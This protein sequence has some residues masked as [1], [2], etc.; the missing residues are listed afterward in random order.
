MEIEL[1]F[2][3]KVFVKTS[4]PYKAEELAKQRAE[5]IITHLGIL[6][7]DFEYKSMSMGPEID[8]KLEQLKDMINGK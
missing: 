4:N 7:Y 2:T 1:T 8:R 3:T 6:D 5:R